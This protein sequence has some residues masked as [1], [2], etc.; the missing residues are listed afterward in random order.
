M[1]RRI[2]ARF[3]VLKRLTDAVEKRQTILASELDKTVRL[4]DLV[5]T[6]PDIDPKVKGESFEILK[7]Y[8]EHL[9]GAKSDMNDLFKLLIERAM[10]LA[11][12][13]EI[14]REKGCPL[15]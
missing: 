6:S 2:L 10:V 5:K 1:A 12:E 14:A 7:S 15:D 13:I 11:R 4:I 8:S 9:K 3:N